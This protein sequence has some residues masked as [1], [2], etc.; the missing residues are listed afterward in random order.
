MST[1]DVVI[2]EDDPMVV[3]VNR[4]F[5]EAVPVSGW[6]ASPEQAA[7]LWTWLWN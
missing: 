5:V 4:G 1:I 3:E 6:R 2:V 7:R